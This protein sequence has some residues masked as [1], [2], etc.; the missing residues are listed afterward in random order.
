MVGETRSPSGGFSGK[1][2]ENLDYPGARVRITKT[3]RAMDQAES[4]SGGFCPDQWH[5]TT[6]FA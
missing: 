6:R 4:L 5:P 2:Q 1:I 3:P